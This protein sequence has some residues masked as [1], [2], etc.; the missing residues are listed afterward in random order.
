MKKS[1]TLFLCTAL[2]SFLFVMQASAQKGSSYE[3]AV[4]MR[5]EFGSNYGTWA[6]ISG[7]HFFNENVA[8]ELML[9]FGDGVTLLEPELQYHG[10]IPNAEGLR[11]VLGGGAG[12]AFGDQFNFLLRP[13]AGL[14]YKIN[15]VPL[16]F[17]F[18]W[19]PAFVLT[20]GTDFNAARF[21]LAV[22]YCF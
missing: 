5:V 6:G 15:D 17:T 4:G 9:L 8:G 18:D 14:D 3:N 12:L 19:R 13:L 1:C 11:W 22:R 21:G 16:N 7:K 20:H 10:E 2:F